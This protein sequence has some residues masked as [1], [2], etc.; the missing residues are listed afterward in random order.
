MQ[1]LL[2]RHGEAETVN[3]NPSGADPAL[4]INGREQAESLDRYLASESLDAIASSPLLRATET[5]EAIAIHHP[6]SIAT[7]QDLVEFDAHEPAYAP[8]DPAQMTASDATRTFELMTAPRFVA[9]VQS[10]VDQLV[11]AH[12]G[13]A[14]AVVCHGGVIGQALAH[15]LKAPAVATSVRIRPSSI[16]R[17]EVSRTGHATLHSLNEAP[18]LR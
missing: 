16:S 18:W 9:R 17:L 15:L 7:Y 11:E 4:S 1:L 5:S 12:R 2:I 3:H 14:L 10:A 8:P 13:A 6:L